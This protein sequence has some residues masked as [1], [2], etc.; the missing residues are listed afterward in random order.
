MMPLYYKGTF[1]GYFGGKH[2]LIKKLLPL[3][4]PHK[5]Y[6]E[7]FGGS[8]E[9]LFQKQ[10]SKVEV[11]NDIDGNLVNL[12][13]V[14]RN[15]YHEFKEKAKWLLY[16]RELE[17]RFEDLNV[18]DEVEKA[19]RTWYVYQTSFSGRFNSGWGF[20]RIHVKPKTFFRKLDLTLDKVH[21]RLKNVYI[22]HLD[23]RKCIKNWDSPE[24]FFF[25]DPPYRGTEQANVYSF[26]DNDYND[27]AEI[28]HTMQGKFM[29]T[30]NVDPYLQ[31]L[32]KDFNIKYED[33]PLPSYGV[34][35]QSKRKVRGRY[36]HMIVMNY[37]LEG[38]GG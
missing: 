4:P 5:V 38:G 10:P 1:F 35:R 26:S 28:C 16:S 3:I 19:V 14:V 2:F 33:V 18:A 30:L 9:M 24:T 25:M 13:E 15:R 36:C 22:D 7:V 32:F 27:L 23:F 31:S 6:V 8:A 20:S 12:F 29:M 21:A 11:Y 37:D 34:T 17:D